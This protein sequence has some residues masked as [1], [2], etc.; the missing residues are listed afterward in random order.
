MSMTGVSET[1][2]KFT[3][4]SVPAA[5]WAGAGAGVVAGGCGG[6]AHRTA[7]AATHTI[8][9]RSLDIPVIGGYSLAFAAGAGLA[10]DRSQA[11]RSS[12]SSSD[13]FFCQRYG[14]N[15]PRRSNRTVSPSSV[16]VMAAASGSST[17]LSFII[18][19]PD[20]AMRDIHFL[21]CTSAQVR[22]TRPTAVTTTGVTTSAAD[23]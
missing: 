7:A 4:Q 5:G 23:R 14:P 21:D 18:A 20:G 12:L 22:A 9:T 15:G 19:I 3:P 8:P 10:R 11:A 16:A 13:F 2:S 1:L 17:R 6:C